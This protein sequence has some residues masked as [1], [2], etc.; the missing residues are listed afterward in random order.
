[1]SMLDKLKQMLQGH[2]GQADK[3]VDKAG[4]TF[5]ERTGNR[6]QSQTDAAERK[7][8]EDFGATDRSQDDR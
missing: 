6:Y 8:D 4:D 2:E 1:M 3:G 7:A 5:D